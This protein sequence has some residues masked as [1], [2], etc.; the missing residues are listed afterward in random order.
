M[1]E[2]DHVRE[3]QKMTICRKMFLFGGVIILCGA[4]FATQPVPNW[5]LQARHLAAQ[6]QPRFDGR[7]VLIKFEYSCDPATRMSIVLSLGGSFKDDDGDGLDDRFCHIAKG[8]WVKADLGQMSTRHNAL[9]AI[10]SLVDTPGVAHAELDAVVDVAVVPSD[11]RFSEQY[12]MQKIDAPKAWNLATGS[13]DVVVGV[14]DTGIDIHHPDLRANLW[15]NPGEIVDNGIDDDGNGYVDDIYGMSAADGSGDP[16]DDYGHGSHCAGV[17]GAVGD[18]R[19]G[20]TGINWRVRLM[21]MRFL[22]SGG[23]G[24]YSEAVECI[25]YALDQKKR[26]VPLRVL[27]NSWG[28]N[29]FNQLLS[30]AVMACGQEDILFVAAAGNLATDTDRAD[31][32]FF[33]A[34]LFLANVL[35][36]AATDQNDRLAS[37]SSYGRRSVDLAAPGVEILSTVHKG[38][39]DVMDGT[40]MA[41][42]HVA[43]AVALLLAKNPYLTGVQLKKIL[44]E[45]GDPL[46]DLQNKTV[47]GR[48]LNLHKALLASWTIQPVTALSCR[49]VR[50]QA[51][52]IYDF[53]NVVEW[54][55]SQ[56]NL[57]NGQDRAQ[58]FL[59]FRALEGETIDTAGAPYR[60]L[61]ATQLT[62]EFSI[63]EPMR[64]YRFVDTLP[65]REGGL[66]HRYAVVAVDAQGNRSLAVE[67]D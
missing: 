6:P 54:E 56:E 3:I 65:R 7:A 21:A 39:Y 22:N 52:I 12:G 15:V 11:T 28:T 61:P 2:N 60:V 59:L 27:S 38:Q 49:R 67:S 31:Q 20:V 34:G 58:Q 17:I 40:S 50:L 23:T 16:S 46:E 62:T 25:N 18:N 53:H 41:T 42:P 63:L 66:R 19:R 1:V 4:V 29:E 30:D 45:T 35:A 37:F 8:A 24:I 57:I 14:I 44:M 43:G 5:L 55:N 47:S 64:R 51:W 48:R 26:G 13:R 9:M 33:P 32:Q 36:V 10:S